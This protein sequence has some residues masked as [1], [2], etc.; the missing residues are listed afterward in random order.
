MRLAISRLNHRISFGS[1]QTVATDTLEGSMETFVPK[2]TIHFAYY[3][4]TQSQQYQLLGTELEGTVVIAVRSQE[5]IDEALLAKITGD[6]TVYRI[7]AISRDESH[8]GPRYDLITLK[9]TQKVGVKN[10]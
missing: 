2:K 3:Q 9:S 6:D 4:R 7:V 10:G 5:R 8:N 1:T